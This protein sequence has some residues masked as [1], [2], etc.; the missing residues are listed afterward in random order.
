MIY[1]YARVST[2]GQ[3][4]E[5]QIDA[6][7]A[8]GCAKVFAEKISGKTADRPELNALMA[9]VVAGDV[10]LVP[11]MDRFSR[12][13]TDMLVLLRDLT[14]KGVGLRSLAEPILD[15]TSELR[16]V[17]IALLGMMAKM[18][19]HRIVERTSRGRR[20][21]KERGVKFGPRPKLTPIQIAEARRRVA[22]GETPTHIAAILGVSRQTVSRAVV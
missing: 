15:T 4:H 7:K 10:I 17:I 19:R 16:E 3:S 18:E 20:E 22:E 13:T 11:A 1:G 6:L 2:S 14:N 21:A 12:D 5:S 9:I 8:A